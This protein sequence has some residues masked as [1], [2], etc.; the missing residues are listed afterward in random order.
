MGLSIYLSAPMKIYT[1]TGD[2]GDTALF[3]GGRVPSDHWRGHLRRCRRAQLRYRRG[4]RDAAGRCLRRATRV[5]PA[6]SVLDRRPSR[7]PDPAKVAKALEKADLSSDRIGM[8]ER[9]M[10]DA[11][12]TL[13]PLRAF[14]LPAGAPKAA[15]CTSRARSAAAPSGAWSGWREWNR[16]RNCSS[17]ISTG[18]P[19]YCSR[20]PGSP[21]ISTDAE[22]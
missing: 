10:D 18:C 19:T 1:R 9:V 14:V 13:P 17:C 15:A 12:E 5:D 4:A 3:G 2:T 22:T 20:W 11:D 8:F 7:H 6:R 21:T 16:C